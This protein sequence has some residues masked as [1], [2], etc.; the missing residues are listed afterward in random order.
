MHGT[1]D[2]VL[3]DRCSRELY[4]RSHPPHRLLLYEGCD[5]GMNRCRASVDH[6]LLSWLRAVALREDGWEDLVMG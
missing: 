1:A 5:H 3:P 6:D 4:Q 2:E